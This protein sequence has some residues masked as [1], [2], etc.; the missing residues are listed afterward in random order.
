VTDSAGQP[1]GGVVNVWT[2]EASL[3]GAGTKGYVF[4]RSDGSVW[5]TRAGWPASP[6]AWL[7]S[8]I[9]ALG[10]TVVGARIPKG[11]TYGQYGYVQYW[12]FT[13]SDLTILT[14]SGTV[15]VT[16]SCDSLYQVTY[17]DSSGVPQVLSG[18]VGIAAD[19]AAPFLVL[20]TS[21][22]LWQ[23][24]L[25]NAKAT[26]FDSTA[27]WGTSRVISIYGND[28]AYLAVTADSQS[29]TTAWFWWSGG[30]PQAVPGTT[31]NGVLGGINR[32]GAVAGLG[33]NGFAYMVDNTDSSVWAWDRYSGN[34]WQFQVD[35][36]TPGQ[37]NVAAIALGDGFGLRLLAN[38][39]VS[40]AG[41]NYCGQLGN[42]GSQS[43]PPSPYLSVS[44]VSGVVAVA[45][46]VQ[47]SLA[48]SNSG[49]VWVWGDDEYGQLGDNNG[50]YNTNSSPVTN[51]NAAT[52][53]GLSGV[54]A[55]AAG[56]YQSLALLSTSNVKQWGSFDSY[57]CSYSPTDVT[58]SNG[59]VIC[60]VVAIAAGYAHAVILTSDSTVWAWGENSH[61]ELGD[62]FAE[63]SSTT[64]VQVLTETGT[65]T[66][67]I[68]I[69]AGDAFSLALTNNGTVYAWG[70]NSSCQ[71]GVLDDD[72]G[73]RVYYCPLAVPVSALSC[74]GIDPSSSRTNIT[75]LAAGSYY[76]LALTRSGTVWAW[77]NDSFGELGDGGFVYNSTGCTASAVP[78]LNASGSGL[79]ANVAS[80]A[81]GGYTSAAIQ[82]GSATPTPGST[83]TVTVNQ[84]ASGSVSISSTNA[85]YEYNEAAIVTA[86]AAAGWQFVSW[87]T[88]NGIV[89]PSTSQA[90]LVVTGDATLSANF[91]RAQYT[92][93]PS[94]PTG[95]GTASWTPSIGPYYYGDVLSIQASADP[96]HFFVNWTLTG[97]SYDPANLTVASTTVA[98]TGDVTLA[99]Y[100]DWC[101]YTATTVVVGSGSIYMYSGPYYYGNSYSISATPDYY[102]DFVGWSLQPGANSSIYYTA[103]LNQNYVTVCDNFTLTASF[104]P[105]TELELTLLA[106]DVHPLGTISTTASQVNPSDLII[107]NG[108]LN[109]LN[110]A[111]FTDSDCDV[112]GDSAVTTADRVLLRQI[113]NGL[114][115]PRQ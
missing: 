113:L 7:T 96:G 46:G 71:C 29:Y 75:A 4:T 19:D 63:A 104:T 50:G 22:Q 11:W 9:Q 109:G 47:H 37:S 65:L 82:S 5:Y 48:L 10:L 3:F 23:L 30:S 55:I 51:S 98:V 68:A 36:T 15:N 60:N 108:R 59:A 77:G 27:S 69:A 87:S 24:D 39:T 64:P 103:S 78:V 91:G 72:N 57:S 43:W 95:Y 83:Y 110:V 90:I 94:V 41:A 100:F 20:T 88:T 54:V 74:S 32:I 16:G 62:G 102:W 111:T 86:T 93:T 99:A 80:I 106:I 105:M 2:G 81:A 38:G 67:V 33:D 14:G 92:V 70:N 107:L 17:S 44:N 42:G 12:L 52:V 26:P 40:A 58:D 53:P 114:A 6:L 89:A 49:T 13:M 45:A 31:G 97:A 66:G 61:G 85:T 34:L 1:L 115:P 112:N 35:M 28:G 79:L 101:I 18:V 76:A 84:S 21:G 56:G 25:D 8:S 73:N